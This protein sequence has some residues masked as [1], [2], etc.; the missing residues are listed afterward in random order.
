MRRARAP[1]P[2]AAGHSGPTSARRRAP[3]S[4]ATRGQVAAGC[5]PTPGA[6][7]ADRLAGVR[8]RRGRGAGGARGHGSRGPRR[9]ALPGRHDRPRR[10]RS[11]RLRPRQR[12]RS[13][14]PRRRGAQPHRLRAEPRRG[15]R[16]GAARR[17]LQAEDRACGPE[18]R[19]G[20]RSRG[21][22]DLPRERRPPGGL[23]EPRP[24]GRRRPRPDPREHRHQPA[25]NAGGRGG[26]HAADPPDPPR[27]CPR[28]PGASAQ[29]SEG[30]P[31]RRRAL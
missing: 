18:R 29:A 9:S 15:Q 25:G 16:D 24:R 13:R 1:R 8:A 12:G 3:R 20:S 23:G 21:G 26:E 30:A 14:A 6:C 2:P 19:R 27:E 17:S 28:P 4:S 31:A 7:L 10:A 5:H 11:A 22:D